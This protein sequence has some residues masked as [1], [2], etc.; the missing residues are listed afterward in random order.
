MLTNTAQATLASGIGSLE[1]IP[2]LHNMKKEDH[3]FWIEVKKN[4][5]ILTSTNEGKKKNELFVPILSKERR[6]TK[7][8]VP[9]L[10]KKRRRTEVFFPQLSKERRQTKVIF[11]ELSKERRRSEVFIPLPGK[12]MEALS[13]RSTLQSS[14]PEVWRSYNHREEA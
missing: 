12:P 14:G 6:Q 1:T 9:Q 4:E 8:F 3:F 10:S 2:R 13:I 7:V 5:H 11:P